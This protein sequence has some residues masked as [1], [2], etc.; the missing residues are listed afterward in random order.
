[1]ARRRPHFT[2][3]PRIWNDFQL[4][5]RLGH[6]ESWLYSHRAELETQGFPPKD[7]FLGGTD[8][9]AAE[10]WLDQRSGLAHAREEVLP[11]QAPNPGDTAL[12]SEAAP[13]PWDED[14]T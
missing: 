11:D 1:M 14:V 7:D 4:A 6:S 5:T 3:N 8:A 13:N 10:A 2:P 9:D 12:P